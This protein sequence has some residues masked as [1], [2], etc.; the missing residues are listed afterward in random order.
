MALCSILFL[1][2]QALAYAPH[3][4]FKEEVAAINAARKLA[5][6]LP[7]EADGRLEC[8]A[9][10][11]AKDI[12]ERRICTQYGPNSQDVGFRATAC[13]YPWRDGHQLVFCGLSHPIF[14]KEIFDRRYNK[15]ALIDSQFRGIGIGQSRTYYVVVLAR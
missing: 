11:H 1:C 12:A 3:Y 14:L 2:S 15:L 4:D 10:A 13:G 8:A 6:S 9:K 7:L 5:R